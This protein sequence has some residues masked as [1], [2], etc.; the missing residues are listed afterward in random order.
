MP[1]EIF[2]HPLRVERGSRTTTRRCLRPRS[3]TAAPFDCGRRAGRCRARRRAG[4]SLLRTQLGA[5]RA[6]A[7]LRAAR[8]DR[9]RRTR[10]RG[11]AFKTGSELAEAVRARVPQ[12]ASLVLVEARRREPAASPGRIQGFPE[13]VQLLI[14]M[15][16]TGPTGR[17]SLVPVTHV[18]DEPIKPH[19]NSRTRLT[20]NED[21][22]RAARPRRQTV[23]VRVDFNVPLY[24]GAVANDTRATDA[25]GPA[26]AAWHRAT[27]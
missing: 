15:P 23:L 17:L 21:A 3:R 1:V 11:A 22:F 16:W 20:T 24:H 2:V 18:P 4:C 9:C 26:R 27:G 5:G 7:G 8:S 14:P 19:P 10:W 13:A 6:S 25:R 12:L